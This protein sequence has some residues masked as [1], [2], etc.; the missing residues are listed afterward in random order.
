MLPRVG[1]EFVVRMRF[2][3]R[4][5]FEGRTLL[6]TNTLSGGVILGLGDIVM[7]SWENFK[8]PGRVR[9]WKRTGCMVT[10]GCSMGPMLHYWYIFLDRAFVGR[11]LKTVGKKVLVDQLVASPFLGMWY[12]LGMGAMEGHTLSEGM[13]EFKDKF[14]E[15]YRA[16]CCVWPAAQMINFYFLSPQ[17]RVVYINFVTLGWDTY[18]SYLK[19]RKDSPHTEPVSD[20]SAV[21]VQQEALPPSKPLEKKN[22]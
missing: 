11:A 17:F 1:K 22:N 2:N 9:D 21:D 18:L 3:W 7:Q 19:H 16:D 6:L 4:P 8:K 13:K 15:F 12:F 14:W 20:S 10:V 5:F